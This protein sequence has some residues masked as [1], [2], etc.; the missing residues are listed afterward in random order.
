MQTIVANFFFCN[1]WE[2]DPNI[3][4]KIEFFLLKIII[5]IILIY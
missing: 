5:F 1:V 2:R 4:D 3:L